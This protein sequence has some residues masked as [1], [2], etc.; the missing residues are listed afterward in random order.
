MAL[1]TAVMG[2]SA[3]VPVRSPRP[4]CLPWKALAAALAHVARSQKQPQFLLA[5]VCHRQNNTS[6]LLLELV[7]MVVPRDDRND[8]PSRMD[9]PEQALPSGAHHLFLHSH[10]TSLHIS[11][12]STQGC[13]ASHRPYRTSLKTYCRQ[14]PFSVNANLCYTRHIQRTHLPETLVSACHDRCNSK[15]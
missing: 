9:T 1:V 6:F 4:V 11:R 5:Q 10:Q 3:L 14:N 8:F 7:P 15:Q 13:L 2:R 12:I